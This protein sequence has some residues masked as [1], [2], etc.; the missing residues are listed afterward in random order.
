MAETDSI[1]TYLFLNKRINE[2]RERL[3][4]TDRLF[5]SQTMSSYV[6]EN[7]MQIISKGFDVQ[8]N[9][10]RHLDVVAE[11]EQNIEISEFK[12]RHFNRYLHTLPKEQRLFLKKKYVLHRDHLENEPLE[13]D[14]ADE[15]KEIEQAARYRFKLDEI[16]KADRI[17]RAKQQAESMQAFMNSVN[18]SVISSGGRL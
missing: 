11:I 2:S 5:F 7:G 12:R 9:C 16:E 6:T 8:Q 1:N 15:I 14:C 13:R 17:E 18:K 4:E 3:R 10:N